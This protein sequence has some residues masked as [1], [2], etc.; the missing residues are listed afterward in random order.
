MRDQFDYWDNIFDEAKGG[1]SD[2][3]FACATVF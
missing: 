2:I 1:F 3:L